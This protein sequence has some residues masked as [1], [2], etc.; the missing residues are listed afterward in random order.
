MW[1]RTRRASLGQDLYD[2]ADDL[3]ALER[4]LMELCAELAKTEHHHIAERASRMVLTLQERERQLRHH[5]E[6]ICTAVG[7]GRRSTD[8][9]DEK[10]LEKKNG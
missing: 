5:A 6:R 3:I 7:A 9:A 4:Q 1:K 2:A 10:L 8:R